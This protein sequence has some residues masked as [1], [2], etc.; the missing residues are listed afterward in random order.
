MSGEV[1]LSSV[2]PAPGAGAGCT[3]GARRVG[4]GADSWTRRDGG[5]SCAS[6][7][8]PASGPGRC[9]RAARPACPARQHC[10]CCQSFSPGNLPGDIGSRCGT[11]NLHLFM[12]FFMFFQHL[13]F[14]PINSSSTPCPMLLIGESSLMLLKFVLCLHIIANFFS[15][16]SFVF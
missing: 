16:V 1:I 9:Q 3:R 11:G 13:K 6:G 5:G 10:G 12:V 4:R 2:V 14:F 8:C 7:V 15:S